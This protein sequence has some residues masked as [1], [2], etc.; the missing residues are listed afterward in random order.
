MTISHLR[1]ALHLSLNLIDATNNVVDTARN[2]HDIT[3]NGFTLKN[4]VGLVGSSLG[5]AGDLSDGLKALDKAGCAVKVSTVNMGLPNIRVQRKVDVPSTS[6]PPAANPMPRALLG[7][8]PKSL[9]NEVVTSS[10]RTV[11]QTT[12]GARAIDKKRGHAIRG[13][14]VSSFNGVSPT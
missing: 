8:F 2:A 4:T 1:R 11:G 5:A 13:G 6:G 9:V 7:Q 3:Q 10:R 14:Y 12:E